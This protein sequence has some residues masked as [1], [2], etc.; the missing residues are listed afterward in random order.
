M[1][2][3]PSSLLGG[4]SIEMTAK[5]VPALEQ[6][7]PLLPP[8]TKIPVAFLPGE[9]MAQRIFAARRVRELGFIP[10]PHIS[11][12]RIT[13]LLELEQF[14]TALQSQAKIDHAFVVAGDPPKPMG[15]FEDALALIRTGLL[16]RYGVRRVGI[17]GYP[18]GHPEIGNDKLWRAKRDKTEA[19]LQ[20]G[21]D[22]AI[23]TQF[24]FDAKPLLRWIEQLRAEG[25]TALVRAGVP[26]PATVGT[27]LK[28]AARCGVGASTRVLTRYGMSLSKLFATAGP[29]RL[30]ADIAAGLDPTRHGAVLIHLYPFGGLRRTAEW[31][32]D[33]S[34]SSAS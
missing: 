6:A 18:E 32:A 31:A 15:P 34:E 2:G 30:L 5:D 26:G 3:E 11:A 4:F 10:I 25:I 21:H 13:S 17:S 14:L 22:F 24:G 16:A 8:G 1:S 23:V 7:A 12:R 19:L 9:T 29:D 33:F 28:F 20:E 27:L